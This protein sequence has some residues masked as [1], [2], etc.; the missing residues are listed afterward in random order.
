MPR[1][2]G[3]AQCRSVLRAVLDAASQGAERRGVL[4][5]DGQQR[6]RGA[7]LHISVD[8]RHAVGRAGGCVGAGVCGAWGGGAEG[9]GGPA[10]SS[11]CTV[12]WLPERRHVQLLPCWHGPVRPQWAAQAPALLKLSNENKL[13]HNKGSGQHWP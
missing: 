13:Q 12:L 2:V 5:A 9:A 3:G 1:L 10:F 8:A 6:A 7:A 4:A 11:F